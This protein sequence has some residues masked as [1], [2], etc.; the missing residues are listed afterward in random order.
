MQKEDLSDPALE[1]QRAAEEGLL[2]RV[3]QIPMYNHYVT[4][5]DLEEFTKN[6]RSTPIKSVRRSS[7]V[8]YSKVVLTGFRK[9][10]KRFF[11]VAQYIYLRSIQIDKIRR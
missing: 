1:V 5:L 10:Q 2:R 9:S 11:T 4:N 3:E 8:Q 6:Y 7:V